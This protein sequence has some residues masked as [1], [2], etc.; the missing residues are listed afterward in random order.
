M[1][2]VRADLGP[3][4]GAPG[5]G[6]S[7]SQY[8]KRFMPFPNPWPS[9][10]IDREEHLSAMDR[11]SIDLRYLS[12]PPILYGY[13]LPIREQIKHVRSLN[14]WLLGA[15]RHERFRG[16]AILPLGDVDAAL[17]ELE[18]VQA[19]G[20]RS[21]AIGSHVHG[22]PLDVALD[23]RFWAAAETLDFVLLHPWRVRAPELFGE[24]G[25]GNPLG[26]PVET[27]VA[28][29]RLI[30]RGV[31]ARQPGLRILLAH[32]GGCLP[33]LLGRVR[34]A[35]SIAGRRFADPGIEARR[36]LY[37]T[38]V[39]EPEQLRHLIDVVGVSQV[40]I[41]TDSPFDMSVEDPLA[42]LSDAGLAL[43]DFQGERISPRRIDGG[44]AL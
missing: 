24:H 29:V 16:S 7:A 23:D 20:I 1:D 17:A 18:R 11:L 41:G 43:V 31:L 33:F 36:F 37:D 13:E 4:H 32:G 35:W 10:L 42:L 21:I 5:A 26:N 30:A 12:V 34:H 39:F 19:L 27:T 8:D 44:G 38:V 25:L 28:A 14:D 2:E 15:V 9:A 40:I 3:Q 6:R 22:I